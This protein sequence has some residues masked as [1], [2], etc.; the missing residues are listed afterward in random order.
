M[1][2]HELDANGV[3]INTIVVN[4][5][6]VLQNLVS[7]AAGGGIGDSIINGVLIPRTI[8][9]AVAAQPVVTTAQIRLALQA[10][11]MT[12]A[13]VDALFIAAGTLNA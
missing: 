8:E 9:P 3:I 12:E 1:K 4:S 5:L 2:A 6:D 10:A 13:A 7:A 11:G